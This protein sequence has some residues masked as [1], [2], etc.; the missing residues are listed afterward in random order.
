[1]NFAPTV[2]QLRER[3]EGWTPPPELGVPTPRP[4]TFTTGGWLSVLGAPAVIIAIVVG[5]VMMWHNLARTRD[6]HAALRRDGVETE[7]RVVD[8]RA[9]GGKHRAYHLTYTF[10][11]GERGYARATTVTASF[12]N[13]DPRLVR[14]RYAPENP[15]DNILVVGERVSSPFLALLLLVPAAALLIFPW[16]ARAE[17]ALLRNG[18]V[19]AAVVR[20][21]VKDK[22]KTY[23]D[24]AFVN[25][26]GGIVRDRYLVTGEQVPAVGTVIPVLAGSDF[27]APNEP[28]PLTCA[29]VMQGRSG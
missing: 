11:A 6:H 12:Y 25:A 4:V 29:R 14:V 13:T 2:D 19:V 5:M 8:A 27:G 9:S 10:K 3:T 24:Y 20:E 26:R 28:Y 17:H 15:Q 1:L 7:G 16:L 22:S 18:S 23:V 21:H